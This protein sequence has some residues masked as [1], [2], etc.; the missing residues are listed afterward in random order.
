MR[1][2]QHEA[3]VVGVAG[4]I[5]NI[6]SDAPLTKNALVFV[7]TG[8]VRLQGEVL[9]VEGHR[10]DAQMFE[11]TQGVRVGDGVE[12]TSQLLSAS[13]GPGLLGMV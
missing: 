10:A 2:S 12:I 6:E 9:R 5:L 1:T 11:E 3:R 4:N 13:L 8:D 7:R